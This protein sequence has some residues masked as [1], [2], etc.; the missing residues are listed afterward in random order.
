M[1]Q[2]QRNQITEV[3]VKLADVM[4]DA[5]R[6]GINVADIF[7]AAGISVRMF[8]LTAA[9]AL[10]QDEMEFLARLRPVLEAGLGQTVTV[11]DAPEAT[12]SWVSVET[13]H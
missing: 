7:F 1:E 12:G 10:N 6:S 3:I 4:V 5:A 11:T 8:N 9:K 2:Q 13:K